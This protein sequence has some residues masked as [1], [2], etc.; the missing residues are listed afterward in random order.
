M[1]F[2]FVTRQVPLEIWK[3]DIQKEPTFEI[4]SA[5][6]LAIVS[7]GMDVETRGWGVKGLSPVPK[8][9]CASFTVEYTDE[10]KSFELISDDYTRFRVDYDMN[11]CSDFYPRR[12][13]IA[14]KDGR[15][16]DAIVIF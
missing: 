16:T 3:S 4:F 8:K 7:W 9:I 13:E 2:N 6:S 10:A 12:V 14:I 5:N 11:G 15:I 1:D